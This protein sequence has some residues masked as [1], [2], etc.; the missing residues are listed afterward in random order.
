VCPERPGSYQIISRGT[1]TRPAPLC[2]LLVTPFGL[3][4]LAM[5]YARQEAAL[6]EVVDNLQEALQ[7]IKAAQELL[8]LAEMGE[9]SDTPDLFRRV[10]AAQAM[11]EAAYV[12]ARRRSS[13]T[14]KGGSPE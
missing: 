10:F 1:C 7:N 8:V 12:E 13:R 2:Y 5:T 4:M 14:D 3:R 6:E 9:Q 11:T